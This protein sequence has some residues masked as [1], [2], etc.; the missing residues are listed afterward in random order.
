MLDRSAFKLQSFSFL[1]MSSLGPASG[2]FLPEVHPVPHWRSITP[3][4]VLLKHLVAHYDG[5][6]FLSKFL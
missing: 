1:P 6:G 5:A 3:S 4:S 2:H